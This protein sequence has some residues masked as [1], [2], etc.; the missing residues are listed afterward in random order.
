[1]SSSNPTNTNADD[2]RW[3][4]AY[5]RHRALPMGL[6]L[7]LILAVFAGLR[8]FSE[9]AGAAWRAGR[10]ASFSL[11]LVLD[12]AAAIGCIWL[13]VPAWGGRRVTTLGERLYGGEGRAAITP[14]Y[15][16]H[17]QR[18]MISLIGLPFMLAVLAQVWL[19]PRIPLHL[20]QPVSALAFVPFTMVILWRSKGAI[21]P[22]VGLWPA[23]YALHALLILCGAPIV[24]SEPHSWLNI[25]LPVFGYG[26]ITAAV[27][28]LYSRYALHKLKVASR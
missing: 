21:G 20:Q 6:S 22:V 11:L 13:A 27:A 16:P 10:I 24:F 28:H 19:G 1:M 2:A 25:G 17:E 26:L 18:R 8:W 15:P 3:A 4:R 23:L 7:V 9:W 5:A 12:I 14:H